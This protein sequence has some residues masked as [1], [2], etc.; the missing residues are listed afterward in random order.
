MASSKD[1]TFL[2]YDSG[3]EVL[4]NPCKFTGIQPWIGCLS[5]FS[6][7]FVSLMLVAVLVRVFV[8]VKVLKSWGWD[9]VTCIL[10]AFGSLAHACPQITKFKIAEDGSVIDIEWLFP[11]NSDLLLYSDSISF[12]ITIFFTNLSI[13]LF[14]LRIF[15]I[16]RPLRL[17]TYVVIAA[18]TAFSTCMLGA[19][20]AFLTRCNFIY[21]PAAFCQA[22]V[23]P[24]VILYGI[25]NF[26]TNFAILAL[27][28]PIIT[29]LNL[30][31]KRKLGLATVFAAGLTVCAISLVRAVTLIEY[32]TSIFS[33]FRTDAIQ[34]LY[35]TVEIDIGIIVTCAPCFP[36]FYSHLKACMKTATAS[37]RQKLNYPGRT[38]K[39]WPGVRPSLPATPR[40]EPSHIVEAPTAC[41]E[42]PEAP[43][44][45]R[46]LLHV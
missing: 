45:T 15:S 20:I 29:R 38:A 36:S 41:A 23:G 5:V 6:T 1:Y 19:G 46:I 27:P 35:A 22:Y 11:G 10:A 8:R 33:I 43:S 32:Y 39:K 13:L 26:V 31:F 34:V 14:Y 16:S 24:I 21:D 30:N 18:I 4:P 3:G 44:A 37:I 17:A 12:P 25:F 40:R 7:T 2:A 42:L 9:D 28:F